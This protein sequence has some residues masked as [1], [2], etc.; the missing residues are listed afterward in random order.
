MTVKITTP[1]KSLLQGADYTPAAKTDVTKTWRKSGWMPKEEIEAEL[2]AQQ[3]LKR[4][5]R[6]ERTDAGS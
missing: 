6:R 4:V 5:S 1:R 3:T 2:N